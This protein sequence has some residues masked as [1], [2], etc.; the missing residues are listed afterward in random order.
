MKKVIRTTLLMILGIFISLS[1][2]VSAASENPVNESTK[3]LMRIF[4]QFKESLEKN[5]T[6]NLVG[7]QE[8]YIKYTPKKNVS[9]TK[10]VYEN[11]EEVKKDFD[12]TVHTKEEYLRER[13]KES[14]PRLRSRRSISIG[15]VEQNY[16][17]WLKM[18]LQV[19]TASQEL[20]ND[21]DVVAY[22]FCSWKTVPGFRLK[23][24]IG[25]SVSNGLAIGGSSSTRK[26]SYNYNKLYAGDTIVNL[27]VKKSVHANGVLAE[28]NL[29]NEDSRFT[30]VYN[31]AMISTGIKFIRNDVTYGVISGNYLHSE[32]S[33]GSITFNAAGVPSISLS[34][35]HDTHSAS[36]PI[37]R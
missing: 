25:I 18:Q 22:N 7:N 8:V 14:L 10:K 3:E 33:V 24:A 27:P 37:S 23:D 2:T 5:T 34:L 11:Q 29:S 13:A 19:Y 4:P 21:C 6:G 36:V 1:T 20:R 9:D 31:N 15:S 17:S 28:F 35:S 12:V 30:D 16:C 26:A 32:V